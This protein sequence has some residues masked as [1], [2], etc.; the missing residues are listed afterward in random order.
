MSWAK[1]ASV[2]NAKIF[3]SQNCEGNILC[4]EFAFAVLETLDQDLVDRCGKKTLATLLS[5]H[6]QPTHRI[7]DNTETC[8]RNR[9]DRMLAIES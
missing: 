3:K 7:C 6:Q 9:A 8:N 2:L 4:V 1:S 5:Q